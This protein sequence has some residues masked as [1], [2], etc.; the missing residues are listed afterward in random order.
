M[1]STRPS[2]FRQPDFAKLWSAA[3]VSLFGTQISQVAIPVVAVL[4]LKASAFEVALVA[5]L[6]FL[7][8]LLFT[9]P[10]GV[11][12]DRLPRRRILVAGDLGRAVMLATV[13][14]AYFLDVLT[15]WQLFAVAFVNGCLTVFFDIADQSY[16][17]TVVERDQLVDANGK[18]QASMSTAQVLGQPVGGGVVGL[19]AAPFALALDAASYVASALLIFSIRRQERSATPSPS[20]ATTATMESADSPAAGASVAAEEV[21]A[22]AEAPGAGPGA[23]PGERRPGIRTEVAEG[24]RFVLSN[25]YLRTIAPT[26]GLSNLFSNILFAIYPVYVYRT[27]G[28]T[29]ELVGVLGGMFGAGALLGAFTA[30]RVAQQI[31]IGP[32]I[33]GS[34]ALG[35]PVML[36]VPLATHETALLLIG[37]G[38]LISGWTNVVYNVNQVSLRQAITPERMLGRMNATMRFIV[39]GTIPIGMILGGA[40]ATLASATVAVW[41]GAIGGLFAFLPVFLG[42]VRSL[43]VIPDPEPE[44][45]PG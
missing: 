27:L 36:G 12:V 20:A 22:A 38:G 40:I 16:L 35:G 39:W 45:A 42:P 19:I 31:G 8:F 2:L 41:I 44:R 23:G 11:W 4:I 6:E 21:A 14:V 29:P 30:G 3:T 15:I 37:A 1:T 18:L 25:R 13:P 34:I 28:L 17:P 33:V 32:A 5:T 9:L 26:T 7:P 10:A 43:R 24:L